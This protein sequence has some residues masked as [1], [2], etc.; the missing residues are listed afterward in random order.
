MSNLLSLRANSFLDP[1]EVFNAAVTPIPGN[2]SSPL[3]VV[4][5]LASTAY[6]IDSFESV[7]KAFG[8]YQG[9]PGQEH[10]VAILG[11]GMPMQHIVSINKGAR[12]SIR[13]M[14]VAAITSGK[15]ILQFIGE[16]G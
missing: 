12:L 1:P 16:V 5:S 7:G 11:A 3:Q 10:L 15:V 2:G 4:A 6:R 13:A 9:A 14:E 8:L